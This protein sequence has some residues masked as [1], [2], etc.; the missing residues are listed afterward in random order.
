[1]YVFSDPRDES[2]NGDVR[3]RSLGASD[4]RRSSAAAPRRRE[5]RDT[6]VP[7]QAPG[8]GALHAEEQAYLKA[9]GDTTRDRLHLRPTVGA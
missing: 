4:R 5:R 9:G 6:D 3:D 8:L 7:F 2:H 1:M